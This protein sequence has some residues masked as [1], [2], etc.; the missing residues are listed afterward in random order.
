[1]E[2]TFAERLTSWLQFVEMRPATLARALEVSRTAVHNWMTGHVEPGTDRLVPIVKALGIPG[3][4]AEFFARMPT[5]EA[6]TP[7][8]EEPEPKHPLTEEATREID[9]NR[10]LAGDT[11]EACHGTGRQSGEAA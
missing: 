6:N 5:L 8:A 2:P 7:L 4:V 9:M 10:V 1:M 3:G 11:C